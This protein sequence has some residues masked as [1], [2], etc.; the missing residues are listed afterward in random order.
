MHSWSPENYLRFNVLWSLYRFS[1]YDAHIAELSMFCLLSD[2]F[3]GAFLPTNDPA[4]DSVLRQERGFEF[5]QSKKEEKHAFHR[6]TRKAYDFRDSLHLDRCVW[7]FRNHPINCRN[8]GFSGV[9]VNACALK[10]NVLGYHGVAPRA[11]KS[12][13]RSYGFSTPVI[14]D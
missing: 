8:N 9:L 5:S 6:R 4:T 14:W 12:V 2:R 3:D 11:A 1:A 10:R 7:A 13:L